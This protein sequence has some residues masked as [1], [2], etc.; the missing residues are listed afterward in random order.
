[1]RLLM[2]PLPDDGALLQAV[3]RRRVVLVGD[4]DQILGRSVA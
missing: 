2:T 4:D 3:E 1:M